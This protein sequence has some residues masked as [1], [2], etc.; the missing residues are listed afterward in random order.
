[1]GPVSDDLT[2]DLKRLSVCEES[3]IRFSS[4]VYA[5][6]TITDPFSV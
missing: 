5:E 6:V 3:G 2:H 4:D 1:M